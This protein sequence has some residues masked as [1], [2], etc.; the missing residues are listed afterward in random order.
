MHKHITDLENMLAAQK[1]TQHR[2]PLEIRAENIRRHIQ[3][4]AGH[5]RIAQITCDSGLGYYQTSDGF[6]HRMPE[7]VRRLLRAK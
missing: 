7:W 4:E 3:I 6:V 2:N 5:E 1:V